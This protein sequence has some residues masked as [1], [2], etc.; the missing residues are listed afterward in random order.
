MAVMSEVTAVLLHLP[1]VTAVLLHLPEVT[2]VLLHP[3]ITIQAVRYIPIPS[4]LSLKFT[5]RN[6]VP[7]SKPV[8][9]RLYLNAVNKQHRN[10]LHSAMS[11]FGQ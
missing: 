10:Y 2:A 4:I 6:T 1:E 3:S 9:N 11:G 5:I 7:V 8:I